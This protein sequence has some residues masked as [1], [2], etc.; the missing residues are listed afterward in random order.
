VGEVEAAGAFVR[1]LQV[2]RYALALEYG[3]MSVQQRGADALALPFRPDRED[4]QVVM[5]S[6][7]RVVAVQCLIES[8]EIAEVRAG[9]GSQLLGVPVGWCARPVPGDPQRGGGT[10]KGRLDLPVLD[11]VLDVEPD[12]VESDL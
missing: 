1:R 4:G 5:E 12:Y 11:R 8:Q 10:V 6:T 2:G 3:V 7:G 9:D